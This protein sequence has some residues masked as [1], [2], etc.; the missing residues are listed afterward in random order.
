MKRYLKVWGFCILGV[1]SIQ[2]TA[3]A[4][5]YPRLGE[6]IGTWCD[7]QLITA[8]DQDYVIEIWRNPNGTYSYHQLIRNLGQEELGH[9]SYAVIQKDGDWHIDNG[10]DEYARQK[11]DGRLEIY[12]PYGLI[13]T[14]KR[15][16]PNTHPSK[17]RLS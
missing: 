8:P 17:C 10:H 7:T 13:T 11:P 16:A 3:M 5:D 14:A 15:V 6:L 2:S 4:A 12:D 1:L 9:N